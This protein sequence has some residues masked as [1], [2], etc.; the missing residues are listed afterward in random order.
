VA[1]GWT[2][3]EPARLPGAPA[4]LEANGVPHVD[5]ILSQA[6]SYAS[7]RLASPERVRY[8]PAA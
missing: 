2:V 5:L 8:H 3:S 1:S 7:R 4:A 6:G